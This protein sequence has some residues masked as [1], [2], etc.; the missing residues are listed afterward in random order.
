MDVFFKK[1]SLNIR[2]VLYDLTQPLVMGIL[3][4]T[5]DSFFDG[6]R[7]SNPA[8]ILDRIAEMI[9]EGADIIDVGAVSTRPGSVQVSEEEEIRRLTTVMEIIRGNYPEVIISLDTYRAGVLKV[10]S[11]RFGVDI[12]NDVSSGNFDKEMIPVAAG[13]QIPYVAMHM[14]GTPQT[15]QQDPRYGDVLNDVLK[16]FSEKIAYLKEMGIRDIIIDPGFGFGKD[17]DHNYELARSLEAFNMLEM[18]VL[19][20]FSRKSMV[21]RLLKVNPENALTGTIA[22]N[23]IAVIKGADILRVHDVRE[24]KE[25][26]KIAI[27]FRPVL[28]EL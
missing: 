16:F 24:A 6:G 14:Q 19:A 7:Y 17:L 22:L 11:G 1:R 9:T 25:A 28:S 2:G 27:R 21:C 10:I 13:L 4:Y 20:G 18:P 5:P 3:N 23:T 15:M 8:A 12:V 26:I